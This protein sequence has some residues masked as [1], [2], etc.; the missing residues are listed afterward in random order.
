M[1]SVSVL[2]PSLNY[3]RFLEQAISS[4]LKQNDAE[5][6]HV[7]Q[8]AGSRDNTAEVIAQFGKRV[9]WC[10]EPDSGQ[11]DA[12][13]R[14]LVRA[15]GAWIAWLN[16]DEFYLPDALGTLIKGAER[17][18]AD[19]AFG[20]AIFVNEQGCLTRVL[21]Q[22]RFDPLV[23]RWYGRYIQTCSVV[24]RRSILG[25]NPWDRRYKRVMDWALFNQLHRDGAR[26]LHV[27]VP[28]GAYRVHSGQVTARP[29]SDFIGEYEAIANEF[30]IPLRGARPVGRFWHGILKLL[31]SSYTRELKA[32]PFHGKDMSWVLSPKAA[33]NVAELRRR[34]YAH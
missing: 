11:S 1:S 26:F 30:G 13:N 33:D 20:D 15:D 24:I 6:Q 23:L 3:G 22:H 16:A 17:A 21:A 2:T 4:V 29:R 7:I 19:V 27:P 9:R 31:D 8:D 25:S 10:S 34:C 14:A 28:A 5:V 18:G 12:L 32:R